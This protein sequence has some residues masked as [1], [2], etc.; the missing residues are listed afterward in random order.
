M[1]T[2]QA[3]E[4]L[5]AERDI[6]HII[7]TYARAV[8]RQD[9]ELLKSCYHPDAVNHNAVSTE[10]AYVYATT[11]I[12]QMRELFSGTMHHVTHSNIRVSGNTAAAESYFIA[13]HFVI[14]G[15]PEVARFFGPPYA[16]EMQKQGKLEGGH[17]FVGSGRYIDRFEKRDA[18]WRI[19][20]RSVTMEWNYFHPANQATPDSLFGRMPAWARRD[21]QDPVYRVFR[22]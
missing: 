7:T 5:I 3:L 6:E 13:W 14:G 15:Y 12:P 8:D 10:N 11:I 22:D 2:Q 21:R 19:A 18:A 17:H 4:T 1:N 16:E 20:E 9:I